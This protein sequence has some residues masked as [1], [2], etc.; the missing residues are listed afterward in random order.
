MATGQRTFNSAQHQVQGGFAPYEPG[1][2]TWKLNAK[3]T[4][5]RRKEGGFARVAAV[6]Q[7]Q[8]EQAEDGTPKKYTLFHD[9]HLSLKPG[10]DAV[11]MP[12]RP[13]GILAFSKAIGSEL[14]LP[15]VQE[16]VDGKVFDCISARAVLKW[17]QAN[18]GAV[19]RARIKTEAASGGYDAR[20][21]VASFV[22]A[23]GASG[24]AEGEEVT[25]E[26]LTEE[27]ES[28]ETEASEAGEET[29]GEAAE[30]PSE[31]SE[32]E[33]DAEVVDEE[34]AESE[35]SEEAFDPVPAPKKPAV[36][37]KKPAKPAAKPSKPQVVK[38]KV[39]SRR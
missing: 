34:P 19:V 20:S 18:D 3:K 17:L 2:Y 7:L 37:A 8:D 32:E 21:R 27:P 24:E 6:F 38:R 9:F 13:D 28:E 5:I 35:E 39:V 31:E 15:L 12:T 26:D 1:E 30:E 25:D 14:D 29:D 10:S 36:V 23:D 4:E 33:S 11:T 16:K 22:E